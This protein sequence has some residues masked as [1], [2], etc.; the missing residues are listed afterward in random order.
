MPR[1]TKHAKLRATASSPSDKVKQ[2]VP[3]AVSYGSFTGTSAKRPFCH[4]ATLKS[5]AA[6]GAPST[7][8]PAAFQYRTRYESASRRPAYRPVVS[9]TSTGIVHVAPASNAR[10]ISTSSG[11]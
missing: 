6:T 4:D 11:R 5:P 7:S 9:D 3:H 10:H 2:T 8:R 1:V